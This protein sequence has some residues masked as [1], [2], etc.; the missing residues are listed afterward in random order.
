M[1]FDLCKKYRP[2]SFEE[3]VG[4]KNLIQALTETIKVGSH[5][6]LFTGESGV[7]KT[8]LA[9]IIANILEIEKDDIIEINSADNRGIDTAREIIE[10]MNYKPIFSKNKIYILDECHKWTN[11]M[12]HAMLKCLEETP[13]HCYFALCTTDPQKLISAI[14]TRCSIFNLQ[15]LADNELLYLLKRV[16]RL[17]TIKK[18]V[19]VLNKIVYLS[20]GSA[21]KALKLLSKVLNLNNE[22][23][24]DVLNSELEN[25]ENP[26]VLEFCRLLVGKS[27]LQEQLK[28]FSSLTV[29]PET[30]RQSVMGY[31]NSI[32]IK[33]MVK[34]EVVATM[35]AFSNADCFKNGKFAITVALLDR[36][37]LLIN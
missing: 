17:E 25:D 36:H 1:N 8:T 35:Q 13:E 9:R 12:Q 29:E 31:C 22:D 23:S 32:L 27:N 5:T 14:K 24:I 15:R 28:L 21:R 26:Q 16:C 11:D 34:P 18:D 37:D 6:F 7:G 10:S 33:G 30:I 4:N 20:D 2:T 19:D 3:F